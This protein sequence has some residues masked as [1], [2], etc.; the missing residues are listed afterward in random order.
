MYD[1]QKGR[2]TDAE[3]Y[4][5]FDRLFPRGFAG[6]DMFAEVAP[7]GWEQSPLLACFH[8]S[9]ERLFEEH[10]LMHRNL[11]K[12]RRMRRYKGSCCGD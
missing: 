1:G 9:V 2:L 10:L 5:F 11:E 4:A 3:V 8:P 6:A 7:G 12:L